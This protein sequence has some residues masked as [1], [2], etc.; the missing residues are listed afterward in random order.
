VRQWSVSI[1]DLDFLVRAALCWQEQDREARIDETVA[2]AAEAHL[3]RSSRGRPHPNFG[4]GAIMDVLGACP[5]KPTQVALDFA[6]LEIMQR[7]IGTVLEHYPRVHDMQRGMVG[8]TDRRAGSRS[9]PQ[10]EQ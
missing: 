6:Y 1:C 5:R 7:V 8:S 3:Y 9:A 2:A 4:S 10:S